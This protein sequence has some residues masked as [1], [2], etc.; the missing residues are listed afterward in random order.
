MTRGS[1]FRR[2][3]SFDLMFLLMEQDWAA[4]TRRGRSPTGPAD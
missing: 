3:S 2:L 4:L 1:V